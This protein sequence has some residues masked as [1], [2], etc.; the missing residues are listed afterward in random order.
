MSDGGKGSSPRP[1]SVSQDQ[2]ANNFDRIFR[3]SDR[4]VIEDA[5]LE[6]EAFK[7]IEEKQIKEAWNEIENGIGI[8]DGSL[9]SNTDNWK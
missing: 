6:D 5:E 7:S 3:K 9:R 8:Y 1:F 2:F 4:K